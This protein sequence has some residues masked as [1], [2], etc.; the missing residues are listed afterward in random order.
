MDLTLTTEVTDEDAT[1][2]VTYVKPSTDPIQDLIGREADAFSNQTVT[3]ETNPRPTSADATA[4]AF[5]DTAYTFTRSLF[6][7]MDPENDAFHSIIVVTLPQG[8]LRFDGNPAPAGQQV[9]VAQLD[10]SDLVYLPPPHLYGDAADSFTFRVVDSNTRPSTLAYT[11]TINI[12]GRQD[13]TVGKPAI[14]G[15]A[16][17]GRTLTAWVTGVT[18]PDGLPAPAGFTYQWKRNSADGTTFRAN[19]GT[20]SSTYTLVAAD[21]GLQ[22]H[23][24]GDLHRPGRDHGGPAGKRPVPPV[25]HGAHGRRKAG[26]PAG[27]PD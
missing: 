15:V 20:N 13:P 19:V 6:T 14:T 27:D 5:E 1:V 25:G 24:G 11:M 2:T 21:A 4:S 18:D 16:R 8:V 17:V 23:G 22:D 10:D 26:R 7:F 12:A 3:V 9:T